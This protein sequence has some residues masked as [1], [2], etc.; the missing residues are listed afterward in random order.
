MTSFHR[1]QRRAHAVKSVFNAALPRRGPRCESEWCVVA[2]T[3]TVYPEKCSSRQTVAVCHHSVVRK[4]LSDEPF[5][6]N[7][8]KLY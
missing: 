2:E 7:S 4:P 8:S 3:M 1:G 6:H 5:V